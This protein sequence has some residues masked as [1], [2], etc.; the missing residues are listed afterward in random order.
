MAANNRKSIKLVEAEDWITTAK[1][2]GTWPS[3]GRA[4]MPL[5]QWR[6]ILPSGIKKRCYSA[7]GKHLWD[8]NF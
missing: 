3:V 6:Y 1:W 2:V 8:L 7:D 4:S 5:S